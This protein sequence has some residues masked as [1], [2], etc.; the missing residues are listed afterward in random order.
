[1]K[2]MASPLLPLAELAKLLRVPASWLR[3]EAIAGRLPHLRA[4]SAILFDFDRV[5]RLLI[6]RARQIPHAPK[7]GCDG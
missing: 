4:G 1:M 7:G 5:E 2:S 6:K 3:D